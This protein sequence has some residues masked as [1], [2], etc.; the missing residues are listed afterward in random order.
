MTL[1]DTNNRASPTVDFLL[2]IIENIIKDFFPINW[3]L[4]EISIDHHEFSPNTGHI[5]PIKQLKALVLL[6]FNCLKTQIYNK[7]Y[8]IK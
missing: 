1:L 3:Q 7:K 6:I 4:I 5:I 2:C 8:E